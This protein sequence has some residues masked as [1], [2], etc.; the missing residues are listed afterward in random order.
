MKRTSMHSSADI[1]KLK[2]NG[3][4]KWII[5][6]NPFVDD[7]KKMNYLKNGKYEMSF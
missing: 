6:M 4:I 5:C 7:K 3:F 1:L 2:E